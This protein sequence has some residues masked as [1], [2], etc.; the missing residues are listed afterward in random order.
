MID[1]NNELELFEAI[2]CAIALH[3]ETGERV[4]VYIYGPPRWYASYQTI[5]SYFC[6]ET[7]RYCKDE[8]IPVKA[9]CYGIAR[10][11][12]FFFTPEDRG[13]DTTV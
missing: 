5:K 6:K 13:N 1:W 7:L 4:G 10:D 9:T 12:G 2:K 3:L 8:G 11:G